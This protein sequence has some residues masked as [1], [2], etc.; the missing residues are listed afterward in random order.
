MPLSGTIRRHRIAIA[1]NLAL[2][3]VVAGVVAAAVQ[4]D[5]YRTHEAQLNDGGIWVTNSRDGFYGRVNKPIGQIDG[6][7]FAELDAQLDIVQDGASV[8]AVNISSGALA[9][10]DPASVEHPDGDGATI[11]GGAQV[12]LAGGTIAVLDPATGSLWAELADPD[13]GVPVVGNLDSQAPP[14]ATTGVDG[15]LAVTED[16]EVLTVSAEDDTLTRVAQTDAGFGKPRTTDLPRAVEASVSIT[17]VGDTPVVLDT[18]SGSLT[19]VGGA[20][21]DVPVGSVLQQPGPGASSVLVATS[22]RLLAIDL[23]SG[24]ETTLA[25][26]VGGRPTA[27]VRLGACHYGAWSGGVGAVATVCGDEEPVVNPLGTDASDLVFRVNRGEILL[28]DRSSG[29]VWNIDSAEPTRLD[30]WDAFKNKVKDDDENEENEEEAEGDRRPP[31][32]KPDDLGARLGRTTVLHPLDNDTAPEGRLL[33]IRS[34]Q[35]ITGSDSDVTISPDGQTVQITLPDQAG[36]TTFEYYV[37]D[38]RQDVAAHATVTVRPRGPQVDGAPQLREGFEPRVWNVP[39]GGT[40]DVPVLPDW[41]DKSDGDPLSVSAAKAQGG[42]RSGATARVTSGGR[43]RF[44][45]PVKAG[46]V[47]VAYEVTDD[48]GDPVTDELK[49][50]VQGIK[51]RQAYPAIAEPD[52][53]AGEVGRPITIRPL[54]NDLPGSDPVT[55][56]AVL[57]LA[58]KVAATSGADVRTDLVGGTIT[59]RSAQPKTYFLDYDAKYGNA[60]FAR[61]RIRVDVRASEK[62]PQAPVAMPD[63]ITVYGQAATLVDV[64]ANDVDPT[65]GLLVVQSG[66]AETDNQLDVAVVEGRWLRLSA[67]QGTLAPRT[68]LV[69]YRISNG[70]RSG[71][72]GE[73]VVTQRPAPEDNSPVTEVDRVV[74]R[75]GAG[76]SVPVLDND[77]SPS[78]DELGLVGDVAGE[79][80][81]SLTVLPPGD[82]D[83]PTGSAYVAGRFLRYVAPR[84]IDDAQ[85]FTVRY[86]ATNTAGETSPGK[87]EITVVPASRA[88]QPPEP[89]ALEGRAV[90]GDAITLKVPGA[91]VDPD[92]DPVTLTGISSA[93]ALGRL[94]SYGANSLRYQAFPGSVGTDEFTYTVTDP[95][96]AEATGTARI[97]VVQPA[98]P[99]PP[100]AVADAITVEPGR[101]ATVDVLANDLVADGDRVTVELLDAPDGVELESPQGPV[102]VESPTDGSGRDVEVVYRLSNGLAASQGTVTLRTSEPY[103]NPP[104]VFDAFGDDGDSG[105]AGDS[106]TV[107]VLETAYDPDGP[108]SAL[109]VTEVVAPSGIEASADGGTITVD[110]AEQ[111]I[112]VPF[113]VRDSDGGV[114]T[115]SLFVPA[116]RAAAPYVE[117]GALIELASGDTESFDPND[118]VVNPAGGPVQLTLK[119]RIWSSPSANLLPGITGDRAFELTAAESY[120]GP[121]AVV[122]EVTTG[123]SVDDPE[124][125]R[126]VLSVPVQVGGE[127]PILRCPDEPVRIAQGQSL[128]LDIA[129]LCHVWTPDPDDVDGLDFDADWETSSDGLAIIT[130]SGPAIEVAAAS[131]ADPGSRGTLLVTTGDSE[132]GRLQLLV[133]KSPPP[134]LS[135]IR[136]DDMRAGETRTIDLARYLRAGVNNPDPTVV[137]ATQITG[138]DVDITSEGSSVTL[139]T[140]ERVDGQAQFRVVMSD[141]SAG[142]PGP[143]RL[144]EGRISLAV[145]DVPDTPTAPVPGRTVRDQEVALSWRAP[146]A[147]GAP[148]DRYEVRSLR[149]G[150]TQQ[151][152]GTTCEIRGLTNGTAYSFQVRAHNR[153]GWSEWSTG[154]AQ[155]TPDRKPGL[156]GPI[157][158]VREGDRVLVIA[159]TPPTTQTSDIRRYLVSWP[160]GSKSSTRPNITITGLDNNV[161]YAFSV[162]AENALDIG[163]AR[164]SAAY[165][166]VGTPGTPAAPTITDQRTP[167][168]SGA[169][170][171]TWPDVD[172]NGPD[173]VRYTVLRDGTRLPNCTDI[174]A[175]RC[176][177]AGMAYDGRTYQYSVRATNKNGKGLTAT[178][179]AAPWS[180]VGQPAA[181]GDFT[182]RPTG[183]DN[184]GQAQF[185]VPA[186]R[187]AQSNVTIYSDGGVISQFSGTGPQDVAIQVGSNDKPYTIELE[188]CNESGACERSIGKP[189][190]AYGPLS[191]EDILRMEPIVKGKTVSWE[192]TVDADGDPAT[193]TVDSDKRGKETFTLSGVDVHTFRTSSVDIGFKTNEQLVVTLF[194]SSPKRGPGERQARSPTT[195]DAPKPT[196]TISRGDRCHD[197]TDDPSC[198]PSGTGTDCLHPSCGRILFV[199]EN[200]DYNPTNCTFYDDFGAYA[201]R[202]IATN[203]T[204]Q[205]GPYYGY[206]DRSVWVVC[207][208]VESNHYNWPNS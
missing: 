190:Q 11:P 177:N 54:G 118:Y 13:L 67:R 64:L 170:T 72:E 102:V 183:R 55:P 69:R 205:P 138:L 124:G 176:D 16:G 204:V 85:T 56:D 61:G 151:C 147:N 98:T 28:N 95:Q 186:S 171:L 53:I 123:T 32:A 80:A 33:S 46:V 162:A 198:N 121:G 192:I 114:A 57:E 184:G 201:T 144:V 136:V 149:G 25:D 59:F 17:A 6:A 160:G 103:N 180:A 191:R 82:D 142:D 152:G 104:V 181:W 106:V 90:S 134:S 200:W 30:N 96:G 29:A 97:A 34:V 99:Q 1:S 15:A 196:M 178:G 26:G 52:V 175:T 37:D 108:A 92:G 174:L 168:D 42:E 3:M 50:Q 164:R 172:P 79:T 131:T 100:L 12:Q 115:G 93:P 112:V 141:V 133:V 9:A 143:E 65:G 153:V 47:T 127:S 94:V 125:V 40:L 71:I 38:G 88:N 155:A 21:T 83:V 10:I 145:L 2:L 14:L 132:P 75:E 146:D 159:W 193:M 189:L 117:A 208:G 140:G 137:Q 130:P 70:T 39:A 126:A 139:T 161:E 43:I 5:G 113:R 41:R 199:S 4:A 24:E 63:S 154:S 105:G 129:S 195:E 202:P 19:V 207:D 73:V 135:P 206:P 77:F 22:D 23:E 36:V 109:R 74:V 66:E 120:V 187:G 158:L 48:I 110:R 101:V 182:V 45:A 68:Q 167:G 76:A 165:Q 122:F 81:G 58:G 35:D 20:A 87:A 89:P 27:P 44:T 7:L 150:A 84:G 156:V 49:F 188:V 31:E 8:V 157:K 107:D 62:P 166:S 169:V 60:P 91:G 111:P 18:G 173:P 119:N 78:G 197:G 128:D 185:T 148:V 194:D 163:P 86:L 203:R 179:P 116:L 51:D